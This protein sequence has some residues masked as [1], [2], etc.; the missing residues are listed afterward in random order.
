MEIFKD[1]PNYEGL[2][3]VSD[4][5]NVKSVKKLMILK[6]TLSGKY[7]TVKL[8]SNKKG[9]TFTVHSLVVLVFLDFKSNYLKVIDHKDNNPLNNKLDNLQIISQRKNVIKNTNR[10]SSELVGVSYSE[11][12]GGYLSNIFYDKKL[13]FLGVFKSEKTAHITYKNELIRLQNIGKIV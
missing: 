12:R 13:V 8:Y 2:Y 7:L 6:P 11:I 4:L 9:I 5:G 10:G 1:I 3:Q